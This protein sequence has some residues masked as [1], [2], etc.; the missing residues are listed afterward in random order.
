MLYNTEVEDNVILAPIGSE[1]EKV[2]AVQ[3]D[4]EFSIRGTL[5]IFNVLGG[6]CQ[7][8]ARNLFLARFPIRP[9]SVSGRDFLL[10]LER[11]ELAKPNWS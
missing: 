8:R 9:E 4:C 3:V 11:S 5:D 10:Y 1:V 7:N 6:P 2:V